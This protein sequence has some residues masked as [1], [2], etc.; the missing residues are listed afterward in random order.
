[1]T[2]GLGEDQTMALAAALFGRGEAA[3]RALPDRT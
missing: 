1:M 3:N 2:D